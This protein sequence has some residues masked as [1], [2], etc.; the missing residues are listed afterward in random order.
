MISILGNTRKADIIFYSSGQIDITARVAKLLA[1][2]HGD[3]VDV[4]C[5]GDEYYLYVKHRIPTVGRHEGMVFR[6][7]IKGN[8]YRLWSKKLCSAILRECKVTDKVKL[9]VGT[10]VSLPVYGCALPIII[11]YIVL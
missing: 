2:Q 8:H 11:K 7:N 6:S 4:M 5:G 3:V 9:C 1:L 10:P